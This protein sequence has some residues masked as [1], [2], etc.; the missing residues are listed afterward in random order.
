MTLLSAATIATLTALDE[1]AMPDTFVITTA[2]LVNDGSGSSTPGTPVT[3][4]TKGR[5]WSLSGD[6]AGDD[7]IRAQGQH[8]IAVPKAVTVSPTA[9]I[10]Q[11]L[12][13]IIYEVKYPFPLSAYSTS[14]IIGVEDSGER[15][16][17]DVGVGGG[18]LTE[19][20]DALITESGDYLILEAA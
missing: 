20:G 6:E 13:G 14:L 16:F 3:T 10:T 15:V 7:Q 19:A 4:T 18:L 17:V 11:V 12:T 2:A 9:R 1:S 5:L 8:R